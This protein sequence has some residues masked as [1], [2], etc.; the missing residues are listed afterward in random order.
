VEIEYELD[1]RISWWS[2]FS[3]VLYRLKV[4]LNGRD[5]ENR[6]RDENEVS[7]GLRVKKTKG[8]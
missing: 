2:E 7:F 1:P 5:S 3:P 6:Y 4:V 8:M